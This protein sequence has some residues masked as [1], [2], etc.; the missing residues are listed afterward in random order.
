MLIIFVDDRTKPGQDYPALVQF[1]AT[2]LTDDFTMQR[3]SR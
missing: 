2:D 3:I 1:L